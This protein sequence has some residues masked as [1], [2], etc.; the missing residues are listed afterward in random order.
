MMD[1]DLMTPLFAAPQRLPGWTPRQ[2]ET[3]LDQAESAQLLSRLAVT[4]RAGGWFDAIPAGPRFH[5][6][7]S[8]RLVERQRHEVSWEVEQI[9][10]SM[11]AVPE[12]R[13][14]P[15]VL[16]KGAAYL[17]AGLPPAAG[18]LFS[19]IDILVPRGSIV[20]TEGALM[21][22]GWVSDERDAYNQ[23][24][25][26]RW[27]HEVPSLRHLRRHSVIDLHH[28]IAP[29]TSR[30]KVDGARLLERIRPIA[31]A[32][33]LYI[34][35]P[36]DMLLHSA[37]HLF[38]EGEFDRGLRD[39]LDMQDLLR[40]FEREEGAGYWPALL[41]RAR[42]LGLHVPL[43]HA[44]TQLQRLFGPLVPPALAAEVAALRPRGG[45]PMARLLVLALRP[46]HPSC[47]TR[48]TGWA[49]WLLYVRS[50]YLRMPLPLVLVHLA[51]KAW[52]R[53]FPPKPAA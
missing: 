52:M 8:L 45:A 3:G 53:R 46:D 5:V 6:G 17:R 14:V 51:R 20:D 48:W 30:F 35:G 2:W 47:D 40:H 9:R 37:V 10:Q 7:S 41:A 27:M 42:E 23:M 18:R 15:V 19:D 36:E 12:T 39:L 32:P 31:D 38:Q 44:L 34:L 43:H 50:H 1:G 29:P 22:G 28:T 25:Y 24:Y 16:L 33:G 26:R 13:D 11:R 49:R 4:A 21:A